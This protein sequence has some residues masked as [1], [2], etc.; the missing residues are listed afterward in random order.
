MTEV[1]G[2]GGT[3][4][5]DDEV[6]RIVPG[7]G[8]KVHKLRRAI[9]EL[10]VPLDALA[11][12]AWEA[13]RK[14]GRLRARPREGADP[15]T[16]V[17]GGRLGDA[18]DP[19]VLEVDHDA[20]GAASFLVD[21]LRHELDR[22]GADRGPTDAFLLPGPPVPVTATAGDATASFDGHAVRL[23]WTAWAEDAKRRHGP[24]TLELDR[25][26]GVEWVPTAGLTNGHVRF[27]VAGVPAAAP[28]LDPH[29]VTWG[30][31]REGGTIP[32]LAASVVARLRHPA[33]A[34]LPAAAIATG[35]DD[36]TDVLLRRMRELG[37]LHRDGILDDAEFAAAK[38]ALLR[39][40]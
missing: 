17:A 32:L 21:E 5:L 10:A 22:R 12:A 7:D 14:G 19:F 35:A 25:I 40:L 27:R 15:L 3:W 38:Q 8:R 2:R 36:E 23:E 39:R 6:L 34:P 30:V 13:G 20:A 33:A 29:C 11:G 18:A 28:K 31:Q 9:G 4:E 1:R 26:A 16:V 24:Q 37:E